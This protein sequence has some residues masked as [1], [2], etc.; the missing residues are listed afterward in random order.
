MSEHV[1]GWLAAYFDGELGDRRS[2]KVRAHLE[3][4]A[5]CREELA[6]LNS[7]RQLLRE[8]PEA[9]DLMPAKQFASQVALQLPRRPSQP[10]WRRTVTLVWGSIPAVLLAVWVFTQALFAL[11]TL[12]GIAL[13]LG[14][15]GGLASELAP[16]FQFPPATALLWN[17]GISTLIGT[18][19]LS[20][21]ASWWIRKQGSNTHATTE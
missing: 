12:S 14:L 20:W 11:T 13:N 7:L 9:G 10:L 17:L 4:C 19:I 1:N 5:S 21:L 8:H 18:M 6:K 3:E 2:Q 16:T 15:W